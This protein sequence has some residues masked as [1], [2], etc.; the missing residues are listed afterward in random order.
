MR[1]AVVAA[2]ASTLLVASCGK[3]GPTSPGGE[4]ASS[5]ASASAGE[6]T[7]D[8]VNPEHPVTDAEDLTLARAIDRK[9]CRKSGCC[10]SEIEPAGTDRKGRSLVVATIDTGDPGVASCSIRAAT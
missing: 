3:R 10:V 8:E 6:V 2:I 1:A 9:I 5:P 7:E 4:K